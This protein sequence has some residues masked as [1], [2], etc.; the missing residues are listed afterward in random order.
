MAHG[1]IAGPTQHKAIPPPDFCAKAKFLNVD[2]KFLNVD[3]KCDSPNSL[4]AKPGCWDSK[5]LLLTFTPDFKPVLTLPCWPQRGQ[6]VHSWEM[7]TVR[8]FSEAGAGPC[9]SLIGGGGGRLSTLP[10][11]PPP[12]PTRGPRPVPGPYRPPG[13]SSAFPTRAKGKRVETPASPL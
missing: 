9:V 1:Y 4:A 6:A 12:L 3:E 10:A 7:T 11:L 8:G 13:M 5:S 2:E